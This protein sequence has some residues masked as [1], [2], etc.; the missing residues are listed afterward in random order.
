MKLRLTQTSVAALKSEGKSYWVTDEG[1]ENLRIYI[2]ASGRKTWYVLYR[3]DNGKKQSHKL[4][5][6]NAL[7]VAQARDMAKDIGGRRVR[8]ENIKKEKPKQKLLLGD[9]INNT[10]AQWRL[11]NHKAAQA[12]LN[13]MRSQF[14]NVFYS[15][16][17]EEL[18]ISEFYAWRNSRL[19]QGRV[20]ATVN[21]NVVA[22]KAAL[23][24]GVKHGY[25]ESNPLEKL[26]PLKE[27]DFRCQGKISF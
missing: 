12:T 7:T 17:I 15:C 5:S 14:E 3:D 25:I 26:E 20:A 11:S 23:N 10:Y 24:W 2:G 4:G 13:M 9:F 8:G 19:E 27:Y 6:A 22:L 1:H 18:K 16:P 21:K